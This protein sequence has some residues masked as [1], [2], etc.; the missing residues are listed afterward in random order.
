MDA[1]T[2]RINRVLTLKIS[3]PIQ[4]RFST[5]RC[6]KRHKRIVCAQVE[7]R[8]IRMASDRFLGTSYFRENR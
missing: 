5:F 6:E 4:F 7:L 2:A 1:V 8:R 3:F